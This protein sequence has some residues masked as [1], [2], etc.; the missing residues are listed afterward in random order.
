VS[1]CLGVMFMAD[2]V[3][4]IDISP[5]HHSIVR[6]MSGY[7]TKCEYCVVNT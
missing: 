7:S 4:Y 2:F 1:S 6:L 5:P 3:E